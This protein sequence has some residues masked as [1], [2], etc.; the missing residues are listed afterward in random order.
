MSRQEV[1]RGRRLE[2]ILDAELVDVVRHVTGRPETAVVDWQW[3]VLH[4]SRGEI[5]GGVY[6]IRGMTRDQDG[7]R[8]WSVILKL[9]RPAGSFSHDP[10]H[11]YYWR[12]EWFVYQA[13]DILLPTPDDDLAAPRCFGAGGDDE[14]F[15]LWLEDIVEIPPK[16]WLVSHYG[17]VAQHLGT[18]N[19]RFLTNRPVPRQ[20]WLAAN[21]LRSYVQGYAEEWT[22]LKVLPDSPLG[23]LGWSPDHM[24][25]VRAAWDERD[26]FL[27]MES[28]LPRVA[29]HSDACDANLLCRTTVAGVEQTVAVDWAFAGIG[30]IGQDLASLLRSYLGPNDPGDLAELDRMLFTGYLD[31]LRRAGWT[32]DA[33]V[34]RLGYAVAAS[35]RYAMNPAA[36]L[37]AAIT[38]EGPRRTLEVAFARSFADLLDRIVR[39][40][41]YCL[42]LMEEAK[43]LYQR[44]FD[45]NVL[46]GSVQSD[47]V[48]SK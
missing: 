11:H 29:C 18:F 14:D 7:D 38:D 24:E 44:L 5:T 33:R 26:T 23:R 2:A 27:A 41:N 6:R 8:P 31:G 48:V 16:P 22:S 4:G 1:V 12:R 13:P 37:T 40:R 9:V 20:P 17:L 25:Q 15:W 42:Q 34:P 46:L 28:W 47:N 10:A 36:F 30:P 32:G 45:Q 35:L 19:G 39:L 43:E 21:V 3:Q